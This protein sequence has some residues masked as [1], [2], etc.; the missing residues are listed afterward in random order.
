MSIDAQR[1]W[2]RQHVFDCLH[3]IAGLPA[4]EICVKPARGTSDIYG[5]RNKITPHHDGRPDASTGKLSI[6]FNRARFPMVAD[7]S[8]ADINRIVD[9][10]ECPI[11]T[12]R[13]NKALPSVRASATR[14]VLE[15]TRG[16]LKARGATLLLREAVE[17]IVTDFNKKV[18]EMVGSISF[19][20][21]ASEFFR[22]L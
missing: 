16:G 5:Y 17:G 20:F 8:S 13:I 4:E 22:E 1:E 3:R 18:T 7:L 2:K 9:V 10:P 14:K 11:A 19:N 6:G 12:V 15:R 21:I